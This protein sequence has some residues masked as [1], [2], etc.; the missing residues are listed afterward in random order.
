MNPMIEI[1]KICDR[2]ADRLN[3][4]ITA[5]QDHFPLSANSLENSR[6]IFNTLWKITGCN[7]CKV[8]PCGSRSNERTRG[9]KSIY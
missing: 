3:W 7:R 4:A 1:I 2:H 8:I 9:I 6:P 5:L